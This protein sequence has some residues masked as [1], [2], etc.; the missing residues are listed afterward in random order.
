MHICVASS[1]RN[2]YFPQLYAFFKFSSS[3][4]RYFILVRAKTADLFVYVKSF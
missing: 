1:W 3:L 2:T 4:F